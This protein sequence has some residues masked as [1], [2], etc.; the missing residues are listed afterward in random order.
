LESSKEK[1]KYLATTKPT[2]KILTQPRK[3]RGSL[4]GLGM[5]QP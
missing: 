3:R 1:H 2:A 4:A 5:S